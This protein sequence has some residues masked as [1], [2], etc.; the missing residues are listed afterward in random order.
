MNNNYC[1]FHPNLKRKPYISLGRNRIRVIL[2]K[3]MFIKD[4]LLFLNV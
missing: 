3:S 2:L 1:L 4:V